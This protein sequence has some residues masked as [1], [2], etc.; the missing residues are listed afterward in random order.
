[1]IWNGITAELDVSASIIQAGM[2]GVAGIELARAVAAW[3]ACGSIGLFRST[4][5]RC[6]EIAHLVRATGKL[7]GAIGVSVIPE[8]QS[9]Q[10]LLDQLHRLCANRWPK[11]YVMSYGPMPRC[12]ADLLADAEVPLLSQVATTEDARSAM[13]GAPVG[14][15]V[16][17]IEAG[18][19]H[20]G[21]LPVVDALGTISKLTDLPLIA[22]GGI[23]EFTDFGQLYRSGATGI[24][25]GTRFVATRES[26]A[27]AVYKQR[28]VEATADDTVVGRFFDVGWPNRV[29]RV[30]RSK[31]T[32]A[33][34]KEKPHFVARTGGDEAALVA[35]RS[36]SVPTI[37]TVGEV[38]AMAMYAGTSVVAVQTATESAE[39]V[40]NALI[41][42]MGSQREDA[43]T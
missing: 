9:G 37:D 3:G 4:P 38:D 41:S 16:Q 35:W 34:E 2:G 40:L 29:H 36:V 17:G 32:G 10:S 42:A 27:H 1:M 7:P 21:C 25:L 33:L 5:E 14:L 6:E 28:L 19:H 8:V 31:M 15:I 43:V 23:T 11:M 12:A 24:L 26:R 13:E 20:L 30:L 18:G 22:A 39:D